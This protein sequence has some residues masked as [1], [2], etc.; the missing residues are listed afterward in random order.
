M[1]VFGCVTRA[2]HPCTKGS[3][4]ARD[5]GKVGKGTKQCLQAKD[6][7]GAYV[8]HG[9]YL[10]WHPNGVLALE[11]EYVGG[12]KTGKWTE[13]DDKGRK[14]SEK[15]YET[16]NLVPGRE[17]HPYNGLGPPPLKATQTH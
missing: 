9:K 17:E 11:G 5:D 13:W 15:W 16:G 8:N 1:P 6:T 10:E 12:F 14:L 3:Q 2:A 7:T 4:P